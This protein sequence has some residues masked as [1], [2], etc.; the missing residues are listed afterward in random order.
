[1]TVVGIVSQFDFRLPTL[2]RPLSG[3]IVRGPV[4]EHLETVAG[5][6]QRRIKKEVPLLALKAMRTRIDKCDY[7][8]ISS[9]SAFEPMSVLHLLPVR[10]TIPPWPGLSPPAC[11]RPPLPARSQGAGG[12]ANRLG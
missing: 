8:M 2:S 5:C 9:F 12:S 1:M 7:F 6:G 10:L 11:L 4:G 3:G